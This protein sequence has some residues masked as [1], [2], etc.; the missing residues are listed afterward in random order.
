M[1]QFIL[2]LFLLISFLS[3][4]Q[5]QFENEDVTFNI[6]PYNK[7]ITGEVLDVKV[8][9]D[10]KVIVAGDYTT[11]NPYRQN[12]CR[13]NADRTL[14]T[15]F[16]GGLNVDGQINQILLLPNESIIVVG[17]FEYFNGVFSPGIIRLL[18]DGTPDPTFMV[19]LGCTLSNGN[20]AE[21]VNVKEQTNGCLVLQGKFDEFN[22][23]GKNLMVRLLPDGSVD[24]S[25]D[26][27]TGPT[28]ASEL[29][30]DFELHPS[31]DIYVVGSFLG[32][33]GNVYKG[34]VRLDTNGNVNNNFI[35]I[36]ASM[37]QSIA[38]Q[39]EKI[40]AAQYEHDMIRCDTLG[41]VD[42]TFNTGTLPVHWGIT[43]IKVLDDSSILYTTNGYWPA[44]YYPAVI[45]LT[46]DGLYNSGG[47]FNFPPDYT[48]IPIHAVDVN[49]TGEIIFG[50]LFDYPS[51]SFSMADGIAFLTPDLM[52]PTGQVQGLGLR[53]YGAA[54]N[55]ILDLIVLHDGR[56]VIGGDFYK[57]NDIVSPNLALLTAD[58]YMDT[59]FHIGDG[60][61]ESSV[62]TPKVSALFEQTDGSIILAGVFDSYDGTPVDN[63]VKISPDGTP[64]FN[65]FSDLN[66]T[67]NAVVNIMKRSDGSMLLGGPGH[68]TSISTGFTTRCLARILPN[69]E[70]DT[71][72][73]I[74][75]SGGGIE[76]NDVQL[77]PNEEVYLGGK[78]GSF[79]GNPYKDI[80]RILPNGTIDTTFQTSIGFQDLTG[81]ASSRV[82]EILPLPNGQVIVLGY[83]DHFNGTPVNG[84]VRLNHDGSMDS[85]FV[86]DNGIF[87][88]GS[89][90]VR[91][92]DKLLQPD[93]KILLGGFFPNL[94][95]NGTTVSNVICLNYDGSIDSI[96]TLFPATSFPSVKSLAL[97]PGGNVIIGSRNAFNTTENDFVGP[98]GV[99]RV[100]SDNFESLLDVSVQTNT[101]A[102]CSNSGVSTILPVNGVPPFLYSWD[103]LPLTTNPVFNYT[104]SG[105]HQVSIVDSIGNS[106]STTIFLNGPDTLNTHDL[107]ANLVASTFRPGID[108][109]LFLNAYNQ[110]CV[111]VDGQI[112]L[113][114]DPIL[115]FL[116][117][118]PPPTTISG[119]TLV[120]NFTNMI[121]DPTN[122]TA[123]IAVHTP[124]IT[125]F[126]IDANLDLI[127]E[128]IAGDFDSTDNIRNYMFPIINSYDP[129]DK[130]VYPIGEC[131]PN[132][133]DTNQ[134]L[135]YTVRFQNTGN[136]EAINIYILDTLSHRIDPTSFKLHGSSHPMVVELVNDSIFKFR[137]DDIM[138]AD[139][140]SNEITSHGYVIFSVLPIDNLSLG[141]EINNSVSIY[142]DFND[143]IYTNKVLNTITD[144]SHHNSAVSIQMNDCDSLQWNGQWYTS[145][146]IY[147]QILS[148][149]FGCDSL[150]TI[151]LSVL[152][153]TD[154]V[155]SFIE[156]DN[157]IINGITYNSTGTYIQQ[158]LNS[159]GCDSTL[160]LD[161]SILESTS[162]SIQLTGLDSLIV[163][164]VTYYQS[165]DYIQLF[166]NNV[167]CDSILNIEVHLDHTG[168]SSLHLLN[169]FTI[170]PNP[171]SSELH[172]ETTYNQ[173]YEFVLYDSKGKSLVSKNE[174]NGGTIISMDP[175]ESGIYFLVIQVANGENLIRKIVK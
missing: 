65:Y 148:N 144:G 95:L 70:I 22:G 32:F 3:I 19:G 126:G 71:S 124:S 136:A 107:T 29:I 35:N 127:I 52:L 108:S 9:P 73:Y 44:P 37:Y 40:I 79:L 101:L 174:I 30:F 99:Y 59:S 170:F 103:T 36:N 54:T 23:I 102:T 61:E 130:K 120:W 20:N 6:R 82:Y 74:G 34:M 166:T 98:K 115:N 162:E 160:T 134:R 112:K 21:V 158:E 57:Y 119:D 1:N 63:I 75:T 16:V 14:D 143:P 164:D 171:V 149:Q 90:N 161:V 81:G 69:G 24:N 138:L 122:F 56:I 169:E 45:K 46:P 83:F 165:G 84:I 142:F 76:I 15:S 159:M 167:G 64:D 38:I 12:L 50:G 140:S 151:D 66:V 53:G 128:P 51:G 154:S 48:S 133:V 27:G 111:P 8:Q 78:F 168:L 137:F 49:S 42:P 25:F 55:E 96:Q 31:G 86:T 39:G 89:I 88:S 87:V 4:S 117:S 58:G 94:T 60:L 157:V 110:S 123:Q 156:C 93:G 10:D 2:I 106:A 85:T 129:N 18:S 113:R 105:L 77:G 131:V 67:Q 104:T 114:I 91:C 132:Y 100:K 173:K 62:M 152:H 26:I 13:I 17:D 135:T 155:L 7:T 150:T 72:F 139:S 172:I 109:Y 125:P 141:D 118:S 97:Q 163:N 92:H 5:S 116:S 47:G 41:Y 28:G 153:S 175:F 146:G 11:N 33:S 43:S 145:S 121:Y 80:V 68:F 147:S